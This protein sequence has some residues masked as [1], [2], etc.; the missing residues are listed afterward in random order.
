MISLI[1]GTRYVSI[2]GAQRSTIRK[3]EKITSYMVAGAYFSKAFQ[4]K[5]W[6]GR[7]HLLKFSNKHG[8]R[9]PVGLLED[10]ITE[11]KRLKIEYKLETKGW[12]IPAVEHVF[13]AWNTEIQLRPYQQEAVDAILAPGHQHG[14]GILKM[15]IRSGKTKTAASIICALAVRT[16]F[17]VPSQMLLYQTQK[18]LADSL[19]QSIGII[20]DSIWDE[21]NVTVATIQTLTRARGGERKITTPDGKEKTVKVPPDPRYKELIECYRCVIFDECHHLKGEA[22]HQVLME[23]QALYKIGLSATAY[24][25]NE[26]ENEKGVIWLK[27]CCGDIRVDINTSRLIEEGWLMRPDVKLYPITEPDLIG[28][29]WSAELRNLAIYENKTRNQLIAALAAEQVASHLTVLIVTNRLNQVALLAE[30]MEDFGLSYATVV[31]EDTM[32]VRQE[33]VDDFIQGDIDV[34]IGTVFGE[35]ID[36]PEI[37]CVINAEGGR[38]IKTTVQRMRNLTP[39]EGKKDAVFIDFLD[40]TNSYFAKHSKERLEVYR[41]ESAFQ[42]QVIKR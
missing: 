42:V 3:L 28:Y 2:R 7:E 41:S 31:G 35:G 21:S 1:A 19:C 38:D 29:R 25:D 14:R 9:A 22:W 15:P 6:D 20:G 4:R 8:Y 16:L 30:L 34:L 12:K 23:F 13:Y 40:M 36:I 5:V 26:S 39:N 33:R 18:S 10:I 27:A 32:E 11:L 17:V 37:E 24:L